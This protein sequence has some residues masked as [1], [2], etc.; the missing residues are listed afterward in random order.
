MNRDL[1][2][3]V[4]RDSGD[5]YTVIER[6]QEISYTNIGGK[7]SAEQGPVDYITSCGID[8]NSLDSELESFELIQKDG[9]I[10]K[11]SP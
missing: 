3:Y 1:G 2:I 5:R 11:E 8:L 4:D 6:T 9:I 7:K 10:R